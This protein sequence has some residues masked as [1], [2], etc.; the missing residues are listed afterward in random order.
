VNGSNGER[1][2]HS[3]SYKLE[4]EISKWI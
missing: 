1:R 4:I 2:K 3:K